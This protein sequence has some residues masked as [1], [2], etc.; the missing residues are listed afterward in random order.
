[1]TF[2]TGKVGRQA[3]GAVM[4]K[5]GDTVVYS[6][7]CTDRVRG[8]VLCWWRFVVVVIVVFLVVVGCGCCYCRCC[9]FCCGWLWLLLWSSLQLSRMVFFCAIFG[10]IDVAVVVAVVV[11]VSV[12]LFPV[13]VVVVV[14]N[15]VALADVGLGFV[16]WSLLW[17]LLVVRFVLIGWLY[18]C[19]C[20]RCWH[21][22]N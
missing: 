7:A 21:F 12:E 22:C 10:G 8:T 5:D 16:L 4:A 19:F 9:V 17:F 15:V 18:R 14:V 20:C 11:V 13:A 2:E 1:M 6:T 3:S